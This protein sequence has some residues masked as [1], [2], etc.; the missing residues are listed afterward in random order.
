M[1]LSPYLKH[2]QKKKREGEVGGNRQRGR[3]TK[4]AEEEELGGA[5]RDRSGKSR[6][7]PQWREQEAAAV[8]RAGSRRSGESR[9]LLRTGG[10]PWEGSTLTNG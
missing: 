9:R 8:V 7:L 4:A 10:K 3:A 5:P 2:R 6:R 1:C